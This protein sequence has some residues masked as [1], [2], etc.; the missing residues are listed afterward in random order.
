MRHSYLKYIPLLLLLPMACQQEAVTPLPTQG[1][2]VVFTADIGGASATASTRATQN[3]VWEGDEQVGIFMTSVLTNDA[4]TVL[5]SNVSYTATPDKTTT[6]KASFSVTVEGSE[7]LF[8]ADG[9][10][11][12]FFA[13]SPYQSGATFDE[14]PLDVIDQTDLEALDFMTTQFSGLNDQE[15]GSTGYTATDAVNLTFTHELTYLTFNII[16]DAALQET[17][18][19][20]T[21]TLKNMYAIGSYDLQ[22]QSLTLDGEGDIEMHATTDG[23]KYEAIVLPQTLEGADLRAEITLA[24]GKTFLWLIEPG[25]ALGNKDIKPGRHITVTLTLKPPTEVTVGSASIETWQPVVEKTTVGTNSEIYSISDLL[26][27]NNNLAGTYTLMNDIYV[28]GYNWDPIGSSTQP[29][30]GIFDGNGYTISDYTLVQ[31]TE[32][33][34]LFATLGGSGQIKNLTVENVQTSTSGTNKYVGGI[35]GQA[36]SGTEITN[37]HFKVN[38]DIDF[39]HAVPFGGIV[40]SNGDALAGNGGTISNCTAS[41][42]KILKGTGDLGGICAQNWG[43]MIYACKNSVMIEGNS[44][45]GGISGYNTFGTIKDCYNT[46]DINY[47]SNNVG[48]ICGINNGTITYCYGIGAN[49]GVEDKGGSIVGSGSNQVFGCYY[50]N[51]SIGFPDPSAPLTEPPL[52][53]SDINWPAW[54][55]HDQD[56]TSG[57]KSLGAYSAIGST[58]PTLYWE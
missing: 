6:S 42:S 9:S 44:I 55:T 39:T 46:A 27:I 36:F 57:W 24:N 3:Q 13:Y 53:F 20:M 23:S 19:G 51:Y 11:V 22:T 47:N 30:T 58:Y 4:L 25:G 54:S 50:A 21:V 1:E 28:Y 52:L 18:T 15:D 14:I 16:Q 49:L 35:V 38:Y 45:T 10:P 56:E 5:A 32:S 41:G 43:G 40:G 8:P 48:G 34:G 33:V 17:L 7:I 26:N 37:C 29:F 12:W 31:S 2:A